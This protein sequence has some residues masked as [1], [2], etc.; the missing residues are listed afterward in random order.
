[1]LPAL[2][3]ETFADPLLTQKVQEGDLGAKT[4]RGFYD[5]T[6]RDMSAA[7]ARR[8]EFLVRFLR[9]SRNRRELSE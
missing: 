5:W 8:D 2:R 6:V 4:G 1:V 7:K 3:N 9:E